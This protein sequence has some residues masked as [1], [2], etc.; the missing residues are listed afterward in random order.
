MVVK[1][2][3]VYLYRLYC[4]RV[5]G[6]NA[7][8]TC[9]RQRVKR[10]RAEIKHERN[11]GSGKLWS[12]TVG[13]DEL[14]RIARNLSTYHTRHRKLPQEDGTTVI[15]LSEQNE[16]TQYYM[17]FECLPVCDSELIDWLKRICRTPKDTRMS[18]NRTV[19]EKGTDK[20]LVSKWGGGWQPDDDG[21]PS[22]SYTVLRELENLHDLME[23]AGGWCRE[24]TY[25]RAEYSMTEDEAGM[26]VLALEDEGAIIER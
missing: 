11:N 17:R 14:S 22:K 24:S 8:P 5:C 1:S 9:L 26:L 18:G 7:C 20:V 19:K 10:L 25:S 13:E 4:G 15:I 2:G 12:L 21:E 3:R 16:L 23:Q 6:P